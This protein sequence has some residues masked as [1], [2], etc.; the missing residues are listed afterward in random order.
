MCMPCVLHYDQGEVLTKD[1]RMN[2]VK[3]Q[4]KCHS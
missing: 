2:D 4:L 3:M 1:E